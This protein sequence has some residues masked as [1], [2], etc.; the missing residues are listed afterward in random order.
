V[1]NHKE[2]NKTPADKYDYGLVKDKNSKCI[3]GNASC[4]PAECS[5]F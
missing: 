5:I 2:Y 3:G 4:A 1:E